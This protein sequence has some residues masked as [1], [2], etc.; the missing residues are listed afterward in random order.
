MSERY[1]K[2]PFNYIGN[3]HRLL[4]Q[5]LP[6]FPQHIDTFFDIFCGG[7]D[8]A[9]NV[10]ANRKIA[11]DINGFV[12]EI[13]NMF[14]NTGS[15]ELLQN[16]ENVIRKF[17][18]SK[19][20]K[21]AYYEFREYYNA[22]KDPL[23]LY[24]LM[25]YSFNYQFRFNS[26]HDYNNPAGTNRSSF[27][28]SLKNRLASFREQLFNIEFSNRNFKE[29]DFSQ[30][31]STDF[32][33]CDPPY[34]SSVGSYNDGKRGFE[35]WTVDDDL[36]LFEKLDDLNTRGIKFALS[37][38]FF[39]NGFVNKELQKWSKKYKVHLLTASYSNSNYQRNKQGETKE[40]LITNY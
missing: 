4:A 24:V 37:N 28:E 19:E 31:R 17:N 39:N 8:V 21:A 32:V 26:N 13:L 2:S 20:N 38:V 5:I 18:L 3:K 10:T 27:N 7:L 25:C 12:I 34:R 33:Y 6:L 22:N 11:N 36:A 35:G 15:K 14:K 29:F 40:V 30:I 23:L 1:I 9:V 16:I